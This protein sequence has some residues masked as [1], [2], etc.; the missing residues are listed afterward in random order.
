MGISLALVV[1]QAYCE[2]VRESLSYRLEIIAEML[3]RITAGDFGCEQCVS[4]H[5]GHQT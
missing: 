1:K 2:P 3:Q 5:V 4:M